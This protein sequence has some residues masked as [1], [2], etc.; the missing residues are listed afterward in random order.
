MELVG[1]RVEDNDREG[2]GF[3]VLLKGK[4]A[5]NGDEDVKPLGSQLEQFA[6]F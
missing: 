4:V 2:K 1:D 3:G 5:I 6:I